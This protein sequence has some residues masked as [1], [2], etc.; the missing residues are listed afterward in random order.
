MNQDPSQ[1]ADASRPAWHQLT[2][3]PES[4]ASVALARA[5]AGSDS[6]WF[7]G[8]FPGEPILPGIAQIT[9]VLE[10]IQKADNKDLCIAGLKRVRFK[11]VIQ[12]GDEI[13]VRARRQESDTDSYSFQ[14]T[15]E[16]EIACSGIL[17]VAAA[18]TP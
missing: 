6:P 2:V 4:T 9:M 16:G 15:V 5:E 11:Q 8:H 13:M 3:L 18:G 17:T 1:S 10:T 12:P 7:S 14:L